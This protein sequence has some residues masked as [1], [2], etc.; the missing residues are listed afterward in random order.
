MRAKVIS[1]EE[2]LAQLTK[3]EE[4]KK[5]WEEKRELAKKRKLE[6]DILK[7]IEE[8]ESDKEVEEES[9]EKVMDK[10]DEDI[11]MD[12]M[13]LDGDDEE[14]PLTIECWRYL[15]TKTNGNIIG[16]LVGCVFSG[17]KSI[18]LFVG[19]VMESLVPNYY[20]PQIDVYM[21]LF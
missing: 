7:R 2:V 11:D 21:M 4:K 15:N 14:Y 6:K 20:A 12:I 9:E 5:E 16:K 17:K 1:T 3:K 13:A 18:N 19:K 8:E 10:A